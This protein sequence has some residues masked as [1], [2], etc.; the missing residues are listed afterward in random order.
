MKSPQPDLPLFQE[1]PAS[2]NVEWFVTFLQGRD[3][4]TAAEVLGECRLEVTENNKRKLRALADASEGRICGHQKGYKLTRSMTAEEYN[5]WRYEW[6][7]AD[8][9]IRER[10]IQ[11]DKV[12]YGRQSVEAPA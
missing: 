4:I 6:L 2:V 1:K 11:S 12:F 8:A 5:W 10:V 9:A 7:K 3:W